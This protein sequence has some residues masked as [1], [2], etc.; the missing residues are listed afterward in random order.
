MYSGCFIQRD[1]KFSEL[2]L[3]SWVNCCHIDWP[4]YHWSRGVLWSWLSLIADGLQCTVWLDSFR[5]L[6]VSQVQ[7]VIR[8]IIETGYAQD[9]LWDILWSLLIEEALHQTRS[10][11]RRR[12]PST[13]TLRH[14]NTHPPTGSYTALAFHGPCICNVLDCT[15]IYGF[16]YWQM[17]LARKKNKN[18]QDKKKKIRIHCFLSLKKRLILKHDGCEV[19][20]LCCYFTLSVDDKMFSPFAISLVDSAFWPQRPTHVCLS[21][22]S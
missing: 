5:C 9:A 18:R 16:V 1:L 6:T 15:Q 22:L 17:Y 3:I 20:S 21:K 10:F 19:N 11:G 4:L 8:Q 7:R 13:K 2:P 14:I 12:P